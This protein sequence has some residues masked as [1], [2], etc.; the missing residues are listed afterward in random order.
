MMMM[1][2]SG[3]YP[4]HETAAVEGYVVAK[5]GCGK[6]GSEIVLCQFGCSCQSSRW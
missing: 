6:M 1:I 3:C 2:L 4:H 5:Q